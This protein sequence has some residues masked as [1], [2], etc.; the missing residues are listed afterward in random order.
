MWLEERV[1]QTERRPPA[2]PSGIPRPFGFSEP[3]YDY[4][5]TGELRL[6]TWID[7]GTRH[8]WADGK[9]QPLEEKLNAV[10]VSLVALAEESLQAE[11]QRIAWERQRRISLGRRD[12]RLR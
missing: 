3:R 11:A 1:A 10:M 9:R 2:R 8:A 6:K 5:V 4:T 7:K 12:D